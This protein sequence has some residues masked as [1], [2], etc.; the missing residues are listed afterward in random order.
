MSQ[1]M[2]PR[3]LGPGSGRPGA[4]HPA[5]AYR[6][7]NLLLIGAASVALAACGQAKAPSAGMGGPSPVG[8][9]VVQPQ[10]VSLMSTLSGRTSSVLVSDVRP[11]VTGLIKARLFTEGSFVRQGQPLY[12]IDPATYQAAF[13]SAQADLQ[14][15]QAT[16]TSTQ[17]KADRYAELIKINAI[18]QQDNDDAQAALAQAQAGV[19]GARAA[20]ATARINL[21]YTRVLAPISGRVGTS[22]VTPGA[23]VTANQ[24]TALATIQKTDQIY[25]DINQSS[26]EILNL[27]QAIHDG[28]LGQSDDVEVELVLDNGKVYPLKGKLQFSDMTVDEGTGTVKVRALFANPDGTLMPGMYVQARLV[29]AVVSNGIL[30]PQP[31]VSRDPTGNATVFVAG[32]DGKAAIRPIQVAQTVGEKWLVTSGLQP[33]DKVIVEGLQMVR[34][35]APVKASIVAGKE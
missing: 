16:L 30:V 10:P 31:A 28:S 26:A 3:S 21:Q 5:S 20:L 24:A 19:A 12:Q 14:K 7:R 34:P 4:R 25:V 6:V 1:S 8:V 17:L 32:A 18:S 29:K 9:I 11:Q 15:A 33:G 2:H 27:K 22:S 23:L 13:D 35:G